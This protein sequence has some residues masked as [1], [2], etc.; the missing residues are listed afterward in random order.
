MS[1]DLVISGIIEPQIDKEHIYQG[2]HEV[3]RNL[4]YKFKTGEN[5]QLVDSIE[6]PHSHV[7]SGGAIWGIK[8]LEDFDISIPLHEVSEWEMDNKTYHSYT[9]SLPKS[10]TE[11]RNTEYINRVSD[12]TRSIV[13]SINFEMLVT[14]LDEKVLL[15]LGADAEDTDF[16]GSVS[17]FS[18]DHMKQSTAKNI[19]DSPVYEFSYINEGYHIRTLENSN[20]T[21][22]KS[23]IESKT[24]FQ[25][26]F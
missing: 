19:S 25:I 15:D 24:D 17:Y 5:S 9:I 8:R 18:R 6:S 4:G 7:E 20:D 22:R 12:F 1:T 21:Q 3:L 23:K 2:T 13:S 16:V 26:K 11:L 14:T 10:S